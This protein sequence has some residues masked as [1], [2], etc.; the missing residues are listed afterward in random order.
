ML[1]NYSQ[2]LI[3]IKQIGFSFQN[4]AEIRKVIYFNPKSVKDMWFK[5]IVNYVLY[6]FAKQLENNRQLSRYFE[7]FND[8]DFR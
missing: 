3:L 4:N 6:K 1:F 7:C 5:P 8:S 2:A